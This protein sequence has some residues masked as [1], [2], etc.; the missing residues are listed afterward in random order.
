MPTAASGWH[1][2][3]MGMGMGPQVNFWSTKCLILG[4]LALGELVEA[5]PTQT[6]KFPNQR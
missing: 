3:D 5:V 2:R 6:K 1:A 4:G